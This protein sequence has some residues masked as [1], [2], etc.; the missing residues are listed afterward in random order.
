[1]DRDISGNSALQLPLTTPCTLSKNSRTPVTKTNFCKT[2]T[3]VDGPEVD[4]AAG[5]GVSSV[6]DPEAVS[7]VVEL[8]VSAAVETEA[9]V[10]AA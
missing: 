4:L 3:F 7:A 5:L 6:A 8:G 2:T 9:V 1:M 10:A